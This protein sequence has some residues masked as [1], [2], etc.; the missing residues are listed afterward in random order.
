LFLQHFSKENL[1]VAIHICVKKKDFQNVEFEEFL[2]FLLDIK[3]ENSKEMKGNL[4]N[5]SLKYPDLLYLRL[6][7]Q[8][9]LEIFQE[10][11]SWIFKLENEK[12]KSNVNHT[13]NLKKKIKEL[14]IK[15]PQ[16]F[17]DYWLKK[18]S[19]DARLYKHSPLIIKQ[20][21]NICK[22]ILDKIPTYLRFS[23]SSLKGDSEI[24]EMLSG[25]PKKSYKA[26][27]H[28]S[29]QYRIKYG[30]I[31]IKIH[32]KCFKHLPDCAKTK[33]LVIKMYETSFDTVFQFDRNISSGIPQYLFE[34]SDF[35]KRILETKRINLIEIPHC[36]LTNFPKN[37]LL[38][39]LKKNAHQYI[40]LY[41]ELSEDKEVLKTVLQDNPFMYSYLKNHL[42][43]SPTWTDFLF[44]IN[45]C[46][47]FNLSEEFQT[48]KRCK[49]F[50]QTQHVHKYVNFQFD[51]VSKSI[52]QNKELYEFGLKESIE[53]LIL[54]SPFNEKYLES[55]VKH[56]NFT[57][58]KFLEFPI[59]HQTFIHFYFSQF[60]TIESLLLFKCFMINPLRFIS[61]NLIQ[62]KQE[63]EEALCDI[64]MTLRRMYVEISFRNSKKVSQ[65]NDVRFK[66]I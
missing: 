39:F 2:P 52:S 46:I 28:F 49:I 54:F 36:H 4:F 45:P 18:I 41:G 44:K 64:F 50:L 51:K 30:E 17:E 57:C 53:N 7:F 27:K 26:Y 24:I 58:S 33:E 22:F 55:I 60:K 20:N 66:F 61:L 13:K 38:D 56:L 42:K 32:P 40:Y 21:K 1:A 19:L 5:L 31:F 16:Y 15:F 29:E 8:P 3:D 63:E 11:K 47:F 43:Q 25:S 65:W 14:E 37:L 6:Q 23:D 9:D 34:D 12:I 59:R 10:V 62:F 35:L 48:F